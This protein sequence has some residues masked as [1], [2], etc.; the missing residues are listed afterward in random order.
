MF[1]PKRKIIHIDMDCFYA[2]I[3]MREN[4]ELQSKPI[5]VGGNSS[6]SVLCTCNYVARQYGV[7]SAMPAIKAKQLCP[8]LIILPV[9]MS[10]YKSVSRQI[11]QIFRQF[12]PLVEPLSL[13][14]AYLDVTDCRAFDNSATLI[15]NAIRKEI[16]NKTGLTASA[17]VA[18]NKFLAKIASDENKPNG[19]YVIS[20]EKVAE[21][22]DTLPLI[23]IPG[24][25]PK[26]AEKLKKFGFTT[27][28][29]IRASS[30]KQLQPIVGKLATTLW[31]KSFG[32]DDRPVITDR[33]RK[34]I[35]VERTLEVNVFTLDAAKA[36]IEQLVPLLEQRWA[37]QPYDVITQGIK[38]KYAD[39][40]QH[41]IERKVSNYYSITF[42][43]LF[44]Q[45]FADKDIQSGI[46]LIGLFLGVKK[47]SDAN[48]KQ[49]QLFD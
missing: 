48:I 46:R 43:H 5:A 25:G 13:D 41:T 49:L 17:G 36:V 7:R 15:A 31:Q 2:A 21:F 8:Q 29:D 10:L 35:A 32:I 14:E 37:K 20:P 6:R 44:E 47:H 28:A 3:E 12:T 22:V 11:Q 16:L 33:A 27:C 45:L 40:K 1:S 38:I 23:K 26:T 19:I 4:P 42:Y 9:R 18:P 34:S 24:V 39:F 30:V